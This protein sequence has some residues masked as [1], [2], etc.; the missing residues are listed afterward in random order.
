MID[1]KTNILAL[2]GGVL[3]F[4]L[5]GCSKD[6]LD[7]GDQIFN[8]NTSAEYDALMADLK[9]QTN[10]DAVSFLWFTD[11]HAHINSLR[12]IQAWYARYSVYLDDIISTGDQQDTYYT[13]NF[14]WWAENGAERIMQVE[15][16][17][18]SWISSEM[19]ETNDY[20]GEIVRSY[21]KYS[22]FWILSQKDTYEKFFAPFI[23][24]WNVIQ[25]ERAE[26]KG[27]CYY[28][29]DYGDFR[30]IVIDCMHYGTIDDLDE[31]G[32]SFQDQW[33]VQVLEDAQKKG[34]SVM[35]ATHF[36][37]AKSIPI[38]CSYT[39]K[40]A[41]GNYSDR[42]NASAYKRVSTF[43]DNGGEFV[44]W[45]AGHG[46]YDEIAVLSGDMRQLL[47]RCAVANPLRATTR[48]VGTKN[49][50]S[51]NC[52][53]IDTRHKQ[54][55]MVKVG[56]DMNGDNE[57]KRIVRYNYCDYTDESGVFH[58]RGLVCSF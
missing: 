4:A 40:S 54:I 32:N 45:I 55:Y 56:A 50:D 10:P 43:I 17:H 53:S 6:I 52:I 57:R 28:F 47:I 3:L 26:E 21:G 25:P 38:E 9:P 20:H 51:F 36:A 1:K 12:R 19:Y 48:I 58:E 39:P 41:T 33:L 23:G 44:C 31:S 13:D 7:S 46:H 11:L 5:L 18:D 14:D 30:L 16:N 22:Q 49:Q 34:M 27:K 2:I 35:V 42:L 29:K 37:P 15:G 8:Y 24:Y